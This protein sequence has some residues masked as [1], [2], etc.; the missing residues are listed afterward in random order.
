[1]KGL[2]KSLHICQSYHKKDCTGVLFLTHSVFNRVS[3]SV[4]CQ[5][6]SLL[7]PSSFDG[8]HGNLVRLLERSQRRYQE[9]SDQPV[10]KGL[11]LEQ[12]M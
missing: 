3:V 8:A 5:H 4:C 10:Q 6:C 11:S 12:Q 2:L 1:M 9:L 7:S